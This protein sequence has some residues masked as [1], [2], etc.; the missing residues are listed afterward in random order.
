MARRT[1]AAAPSGTQRNF[2]F[3]EAGT[4][5]YFCSVHPHMTGKVVQ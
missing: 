1:S 4:Y 3:D 5:D 2:Q